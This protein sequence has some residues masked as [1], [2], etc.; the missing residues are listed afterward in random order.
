MVRTNPVTTPQVA[1][2]WVSLDTHRASRVDG[3]LA[4]PSE[5]F[6]TMTGVGG[7]N[8]LG[9]SAT[10]MVSPMFFASPMVWSQALV[11]GASN[12]FIQCACS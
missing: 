4:S 10:E 7:L 3:S 8:Y 9:G 5:V 2:G 12:I 11:L 6:R 1:G